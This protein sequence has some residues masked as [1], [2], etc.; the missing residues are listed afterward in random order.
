[1]SL[2]SRSKHPFHSAGGWESPGAEWAVNS[3]SGL[4]PVPVQSSERA[5]PAL[6]QGDGWQRERKKDLTA[7]CCI[8]LNYVGLVLWG[9]G[10]GMKMLGLYLVIFYFGSYSS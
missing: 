9:G 10:E 7:F 3:S 2:I 5:I 4:D 1:M 8:N 6:L